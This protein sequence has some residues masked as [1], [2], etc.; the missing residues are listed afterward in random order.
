MCSTF[1]V[2]SIASAY[3]ICIFVTTF[4]VHLGFTHG[5]TYFITTNSQIRWSVA[6]KK[7]KG[8]IS[9]KIIVFE[10]YLLKTGVANLDL[11]LIKLSIR[12]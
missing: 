2:C 9:Y 7:V 10:Q 5:D 1:Q 3:I 11:Y 8:V 4:F 12:E 6:Q